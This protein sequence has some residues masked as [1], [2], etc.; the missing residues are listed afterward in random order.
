M[1]VDAGRCGNSLVE[2]RFL[3]SLEGYLVIDPFEGADVAEIRV[4]AFIR[5]YGIDKEVTVELEVCG[6]TV[7]RRVV[8]LPRGGRHGVELYANVKNDCT[9]KLAVNGNTLDMQKIDMHS[10]SFPENPTS[11][12][13]VFHSHQPPNY[14]PDRV[15]KDLW[16][17]TY[18]WRPLLFPYGLGPYH[19]HAVLLKETSF[20]IRLVYNLSPSLIKQWTDLV[21]R[22]IETVTGEALQPYSEL[23]KV[24]KETMNTYKEL[25]SSGIIEILTSIY[26]HTIAGYIVDALGLSDV[27]RRELEYGYSI[28]EEFTGTK[29][30]G[31][32]LPEMSFSMN[33][34]PVLKS[35]NLEYTFLDEKY[36][37]KGAEGDIRDHYEP[38][39]VQ[40]RLGN[41]L[42]VLFR[43][44]ELSNDVAFANNYC[45]DI[46]ALK[47]AYTFISKLVKK[48]TENKARVLTIA[49][50]GENW[51][52]FS[53]NPPATAVFLEVTL[54]LFK[55]LR[56]LGLAK[57]A[58]AREVLRSAPPARKLRYVPPTTWLGSYNKWRGE[59]VEHEVFWRMVEQRITRYKEYVLKHG[60]NEKARK[61]EWA[62]WHVLDS[63]YW[64]AEFWNKEMITLWINEFDKYIS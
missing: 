3:D 59:R 32:W 6:N 31:V 37:F 43:D 28:T 52:V 35:Q 56:E 12:L 51:M 38:Y 1:N 17:F 58:T 36:H 30:E 10:V 64:W 41:S 16:P 34:I 21:E 50:D 60:L 15:Y 54:S 5:N 13:V 8:K 20:D 33:L 27:L 9:A 42:T 18:V 24:I 14:R 23:A 2:P 46:H 53:K 25:A 44:T 26:A 47:G 39:I 57:L 49:L 7:D 40:D 45:S 55:K 22:G 4:L 19:Y 62:L 63:D 48:C 61:A 29:P 11:V